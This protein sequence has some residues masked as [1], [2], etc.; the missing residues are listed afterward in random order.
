MVCAILRIDA[1]EKC[2]E[3][4]ACQKSAPRKEGF[5][6]LLAQDLRLS[7]WKRDII[8]RDDAWME[9]RREGEER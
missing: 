8:Q 4:L 6:I 3:F 5:E 9:E 1:V 7:A 2:S